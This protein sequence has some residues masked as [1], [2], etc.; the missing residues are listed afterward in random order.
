MVDRC[1]LK[2]TK[3][4]ECIFNAF[5]CIYNILHCIGS[6]FQCNSMHLW[7]IS[8]YFMYLKVFEFIQMSILSILMFLKCIYN[9]FMV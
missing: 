3:V 8:M 9:I 4:F 6:I 7:Y 2:D 5:G 1:I